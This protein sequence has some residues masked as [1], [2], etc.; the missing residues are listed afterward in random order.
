MGYPINQGYYNEENEYVGPEETI[1]INSIR[2]YGGIT[3]SVLVMSS[4]SPR[5]TERTLNITVSPAILKSMSKMT[6]EFVEYYE[7]EI[8]K[9]PD[10]KAESGPSEKMR[11]E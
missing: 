8:G 7:K 1:Y 11:D 4:D 2:M 10:L 6:T 9:I 3:D 5:G